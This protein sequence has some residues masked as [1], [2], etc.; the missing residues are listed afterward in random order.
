MEMF[1]AGLEAE[2]AVVNALPVD[3]IVY[4]IAIFAALMF[5]LLA[6]MSLRS[7]GLRPDTPAS[8]EVTQPSQGSTSS[9][10]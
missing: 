7:V 2:N 5:L 9:N 3:P 6:I 8:T 10:S 4:G 1:F